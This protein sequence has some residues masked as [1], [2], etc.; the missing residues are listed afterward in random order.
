MSRCRGLTGTLGQNRAGGD[1]TIQL[2][3]S[4][5]FTKVTMLDMVLMSCCVSVHNIRA[6]SSYV[7]SK[8]QAC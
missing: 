5:V 3:I 7:C 1:V 2:K 8:S 6:T 4:C